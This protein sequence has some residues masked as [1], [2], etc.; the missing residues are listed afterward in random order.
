MN[1]LI[2]CDWGTSRFRLRWF[3]V[4]RQRIVAE[5]ATDQGIQAIAAAH[6]AGAA[7]REALGNV[8]ENGISG[9]GIR[10][11]PDIPVVVSGMAS[12]TLGW[13]S[14]PYAPLPAPV[15][16]STL[17]FVDFQHA[18]RRVRLISGLR[19]GSDVMRG[20][21]T[22]LIGLFDSPARRP[23]ADDS[24]V[25]MPG[26]HSKHVTLRGGRI[27]D[28]TTHLTGEL[29]ALLCQNSSLEISGDAVFSEAAFI[30]GTQAGRNLSL[31]AALFQTRAR[32]VLQQLPAHHNRAFLS[33]VL[34]GA[35]VAALSNI[36]ATQIVLVAAEP[37]A[38]QYILALR[39]VLPAIPA[40]QI[41][42]EELAAAIVA[43]HVRIMS[44]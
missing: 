3:D 25:I 8:L 32:T 9:L 34:I 35:E 40:V 33:G 39:A 26:T 37:L 1:H 30:A 14:L 23:M 6:P 29:Y 38:A 15:D 43:G 28:F 18:G 22:E 44:R 4:A 2:S 13:Q 41:P 27:T 21:E 7:R 12:S 17:Q 36:R 42:T 19:A 31:T 16:G 11:A 10:D 20:E 24:V 5:Y